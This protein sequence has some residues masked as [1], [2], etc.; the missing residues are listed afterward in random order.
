MLLYSTSNDAK[1]V[2]LK[3]SE[4]F[5]EV[6]KQE[7]DDKPVNALFACNK[8]MEEDM[9]RLFKFFNSE[10]T[11]TATG[12][13]VSDYMK[14]TTLKN[15]VQWMESYS[16]WT[17]VAKTKEDQMNATLGTMVE[18]MKSICG[19]L[20]GQIPRTPSTTGS[21][22][23]MLTT[24]MGHML[25][26]HESPMAAFPT[27]PGPMRSSVAGPGMVLP[28]ALSPV[29]PRARLPTGAVDGPAQ[30]AAPDTSNM[31]E[32]ERM[33]FYNNWFHSLSGASMGGG[34][35]PMGPPAADRPMRSPSASPRSVMTDTP[36]DPPLGI[37][38]ETARFRRCKEQAQ[39]MMETYMMGT[40]DKWRAFLLGIQQV[41]ESFDECFPK[42]KKKKL[43][44]TGIP[45][46]HLGAEFRKY[47]GGDTSAKPKL[48][49]WSDEAAAQFVR[50]LNEENI[51][52]LA[53]SLL[54]STPA[55]LLSVTAPVPFLQRIAQT[56]N[57]AYE[58]D[59]HA[60]LLKVTIGATMRAGAH[61]P[62]WAADAR[63]AAG[64]MPA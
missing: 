5:A 7:K 9:T 22:T 36:D 64:S 49:V 12:E 33:H 32:I 10:H 19:A 51:K 55:F 1:E 45:G 47:V 15:L 38:T 21:S 25:S 44:K 3:V 40:D 2:S 23:D 63:M 58:G 4:E 11:V 20:T 29:I 43:A 37:E 61:D 48:V 62:P 60:L 54:Y 18:T 6:L 59:V 34:A 28:P 27:S 26:S 39:V 46:S 24:P 8:S 14:T 35:A 42:T 41:R 31:S 13:S 57:L 16:G 53:E 50:C 52:V 30:M 17:K 56:W